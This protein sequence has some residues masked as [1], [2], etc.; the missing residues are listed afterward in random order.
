LLFYL[1]DIEV[2]MKNLK[3]VTLENIDHIVTPN[4]FKKITLDSPATMIFTDFKAFNPLIIE[5]N[6]KAVDALHLMRKAH[7]HLKIVMSDN[8]D[9]VGVISSFDISEQRIMHKVATGHAREDILV[10]DLMLPR[11][12][13]MAFD[14]QELKHSTVNNV[15]DALKQNGLRHCLVMDSKNHHIRGIISSSDIARKLHIPIEITTNVTF[16][17][18]FNAVNVE[19]IKA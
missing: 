10:S 8:D 6:T 11:S 17:K 19:S 9:F 7:V 13:L 3:L 15:I 2:L 18:I 5:A 16:A 14:I 12:R 1:K 4:D